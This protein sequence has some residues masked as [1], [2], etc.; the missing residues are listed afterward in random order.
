MACQARQPLQEDAGR[1]A[2]GE[3]T[4][5]RRR[6]VGLGGVRR[7][8]SER[9]QALR[10]SISHTRKTKI[11]LP[12]RG[13]VPDG[14]E[15]EAHRDA[16]ARR[17]GGAACCRFEYQL[18]G[19]LLDLVKNTW[20][21][22]LPNLIVACDGRLRAPAAARHDDARRAAAIPVVARRRAAPPAP[23][24]PTAPPASFPV[25]AEARMR[26]RARRSPPAAG[27]AAEKSSHRRGGAK[28]A[29]A[30]PPAAPAAA[31]RRRTTSS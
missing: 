2:V 20:R 11:D 8:G 30:A 16:A 3:R 21:L 10:G 18:R 22:E 4:P 12:L 23:P 26:C 1:A 13:A 19:E 28:V 17:N 15:G 6:S 7:C 5:L 24:P 27:N 25:A 9:R 14:G 31:R 29:P